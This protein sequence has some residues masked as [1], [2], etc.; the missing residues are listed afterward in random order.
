MGTADSCTERVDTEVI[1]VGTAQSADFGEGDNVALEV[2]VIDVALEVG[3]VGLG[4][5][6]MDA[7][8][9]SVGL[10]IESAEIDT[11]EPEGQIHDP[12]GT[13][14][15]TDIAG[16]EAEAAGI[17]LAADFVFPKIVGQSVPDLV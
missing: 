16:A 14:E 11:A 1:E 8:A 4:N 2:V 6:E 13:V 7:A 5:M 17:V 12:V 9:E 3:E 15:A 10:D